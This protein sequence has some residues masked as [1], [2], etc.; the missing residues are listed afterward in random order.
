VGVPTQKSSNLSINFR[1]R[2]ATACTAPG[3]DPISSGAPQCEGSPGGRE[4][5]LAADSR[6]VIAISEPQVFQ[7]LLG[8]FQD[9]GMGQSP[10]TVP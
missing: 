6:E 7:G 3:D 1:A 2:G 9:L 4:P 5:R 10:G 8:I